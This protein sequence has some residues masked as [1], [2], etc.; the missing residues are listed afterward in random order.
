MSAGSN[1]SSGM[2]SSSGSSWGQ[3]Y[4]TNAGSASN[5]GSGSNWGDNR[6]RGKS[7]N[8]SRGYSESMEYAIEPGDFAR[9]LKTGGREN[10]NEVTG[11]WFQAGRKFKASG[12]NWLLARFK[13]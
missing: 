5:S 2:S 12:T 10:G 7:E 3:G 1:E 13:Q 6:G 8:V 11:I 9:M 4:S